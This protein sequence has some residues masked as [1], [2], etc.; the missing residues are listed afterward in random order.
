MLIIF[1][2]CAASLELKKTA[3][4][5]ISFFSNV[6]NDNDFNLTMK[7]SLFFLAVIVG[8][9][10]GFDE[11]GA[12][13]QGYKGDEHFCKDKVYKK[14]FEECVVSKAVENGANLGPRRLE[15]RGNRDLLSCSMC[16]DNPWRGHWCFVKCGIGRRRL[17]FTDEHPERILVARG[18]IQKD[19]NDCLHEKADEAEYACLGDK[20][21]LK[22]K[23]FFNSE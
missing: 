14:L 13:I 2:F 17:T 3:S 8:T 23:I 21:E 1:F 18:K 22:I 19:A 9:G 16:P 20:E 4:S 10:F 7:Y 11:L 5:S 15:L 12:Q 6:F